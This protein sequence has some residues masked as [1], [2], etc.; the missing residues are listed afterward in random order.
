MSVEGME[1]MAFHQIARK[2]MC[3]TM[4]HKWCCGVYK[5]H[6]KMFSWHFDR[7]K[8]QGGPKIQTLRNCLRRC[9]F[10]EYIQ[11]LWLCGR[12][13]VIHPPLASMSM[14]NICW[15]HVRKFSNFSVGITWLCWSPTMF[16][17]FLLVMIRLCH[18]PLSEMD[19]MGCHWWWPHH[20]SC[21]YHSPYLNGISQKL[22]NLMLLRLRLVTVHSKRWGK[23][24]NR[25]TG[26]ADFKFSIGTDFLNWDAMRHDWGLPSIPVSKLL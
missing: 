22:F 21:H 19:L 2:F 25:R 24:F 1:G 14:T 15:G 13:G 23:L 20:I 17:S 12:S 7:W 5:A 11:V 4:V 18:T 8:G 26:K 3:C 9:R 6:G 10:S 16:G